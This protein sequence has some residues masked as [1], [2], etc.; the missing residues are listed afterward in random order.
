MRRKFVL[1]LALVGLASALSFNKGYFEKNAGQ[2]DG[3]VLF[4]GRTPDFNV[5]FLQNEVVLSSRDGKETIKLRMVEGNP[6]EVV[7]EKPLELK[8]NYIK[9]NR[10]RIKSV[11]TY[12]RVR[13]KEVWPGIDLVFYFRD[14]EQLEFDLE[15]RAGADLS[16][17]RIKP[18][19]DEVK[20]GKN[21]V[22]LRSGSM[23]FLV[24]IPEA[25]TV[26]EG[27]RGRKIEARFQSVGNG[28]FV[29]EAGSFT[30][31]IIIDP[32]FLNYS[33]Y[34]GG[35]SYDYAYGNYV[36]K[37]GNQYVTGWTYSSDYPTTP[38]SF[39]ENKPGHW[40]TFLVKISPDGSTPVF[41]TYLGGSSIDV[42]YSVVVDDQ[43]NVY[44]AGATWSNNYPL[45]NPLQST[46]KGYHDCFITELTPDGSDLVFSTYWGGSNWD[47]VFRM[48]LTSSRE[49]IL[50]GVTR[51]SD[52]PLVSPIQATYGGN[53]DTFV[54]KFL[55]DGAGVVFSTYL[56]GSGTEWGYDITSDPQGNIYVT[57]WTTST[58]FPV[59]AAL[60]PTPGGNTDGFFVKLKG[61]GSSFV[62]SSYLGGSGD[63]RINGF[64][65]D[66]VGDIYLCGGT[67]STDFPTQKALQ[68]ALAGGKD[69]FITKVFRTGDKLIYSTYIGGSGDD[70]AADVE[71]N[72]LMEPTVTGGTASSDFPVKQEIFGYSGNWDLFVLRLSRSG[73][74][75]IFSTYLG[76]SNYDQSS[77]LH[78]GGKG[79]IYISGGTNSSDFPVLNPMQGSFAGGSYDGIA[80]KLTYN[81]PPVAVIKG[82]SQACLAQE[83]I[84]LDGSSS[85]DRDGRIVTYQWNLEKKP[86]G[87]SATLKPAGEKAYLVPDLPG[88][89]EVSLRVMDNSGEWSRK[90]FFTIK[91]G[92][93]NLRIEIEGQRTE[94]RAWIIK[95][96]S[97]H[98]FLRYYPSSCPITPS[99]FVLYRWKDGEGKEKIAEMRPGDFTWNESG[100]YFQMEYT[101]GSLEPG[102]RYKYRL[103]ALDK[104]GTLLGWKEAE[105]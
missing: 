28:E 80:V 70:E 105:F 15:A 35:S 39:Q 48:D 29:L 89:Y 34:A 73:S 93:P 19:A 87:S 99:R 22:L 10:K 72:E 51:S 55:P 76:G 42:G 31:G 13:L 103:E 33:T 21:E 66:P 45:K 54:V 2:W 25:V 18:S 24:K 67:D 30:S 58:D 81:D 16:R 84:V 68:P 52:F 12:S 20:I 1:F 26:E 79:S 77:S 88:R 37:K 86:A 61:D 90:T 43:G 60:Q 92:Q 50:T 49:I 96:D 7:G 38:G 63:D 44:V 14:E 9:G 47:W 104:K 75:L 6:V 85:H 27:R 83:K 17:A 59:V 40:D 71:V 41:A 74:S 94:D 4:L 11:P 95:S 57:G 8:V 62:F 69:G 97:V 32:L 56:G 78:L 91:V 3:K 36:D 98:L 5:W 46:H 23:K 101:D 65:V 53:D 102:V 82:D 100:G 64:Y